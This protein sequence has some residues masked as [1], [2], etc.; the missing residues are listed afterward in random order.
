MAPLQPHRT[1]GE[2]WE[3]GSVL[4]PAAGCQPATRSTVAR[5]QELFC[6]STGVKEWVFEPSLLLYKLLQISKNLNL[7][8]IDNT[9]AT[10]YSDKACPIYMFRTF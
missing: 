7:D 4:G 9:K 5:S 3:V 6:V 10:N 1:V 8:F 2:R